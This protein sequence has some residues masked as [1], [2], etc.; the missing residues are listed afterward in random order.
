MAQAVAM[1]LLPFH[2]RGDWD[3]ALQVRRSI[4]RSPVLVF[5][6]HEKP[7]RSVRF[8]LWKVKFDWT[9]PFAESPSTTVG[10]ELKFLPGRLEWQ[11]YCAFFAGFTSLLASCRL[12]PLSPQLLASV[13]ATR[14]AS[15]ERNDW[16]RLS[17][18]LEVGIS[19][20]TTFIAMVAV[21]LVSSLTRGPC[22]GVPSSSAC[23]MVLRLMLRLV[24]VVSYQ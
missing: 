22:L 21:T 4:R 24:V 15:M 23:Q 11:V 18:S 1:E 19:S 7:E 14:A 17:R 20:S 9:S 13:N 2:D 8:H 12:H 6:R 16:Y 3:G 10:A 5:N